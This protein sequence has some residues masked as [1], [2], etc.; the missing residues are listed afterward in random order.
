MYTTAERTRKFNLGGGL[1]LL[2]A[3]MALLFGRESGPQAQTTASPDRLAQQVVERTNAERAKYG[4][5]PLKRQDDLDT[6][7]RW[8][9]QD[10]AGRNYFDHT[11]RQGRNVNRRLPDF[12]YR[13]FQD[14]GENIASGQASPDSVV[15]D[16]MHSPGHRANILDPK[17]REIGVGY[18]VGR[19]G[20]LRRYWVQDFGRRFDVYP[21]VIN[22]E[23]AQTRRPDVKLTI[24]GEGWA[25][26]MRLSNDGRNWT[27]WEAYQSDRSWT[28][29]AGRGRRS[30][31]VELRRDGDVRRASDSIE[32]VSE[33]R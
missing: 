2:G 3:L 31:F 13:D 24:Y 4:L 1:L 30:V 23:A 26:E 7:A 27:P 6:A 33:A 29:E 15:A 8:M 22:G 32:L 17:F 5:P 10:M 21:V 20:R 16:W 12:G 25:S 9:A 18:A 14:I 28:L 11:D 19:T